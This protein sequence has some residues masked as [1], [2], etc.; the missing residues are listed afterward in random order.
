VLV[1]KQDM[2]TMLR[3]EQPTAS[4]RWSSMRWQ[5]RLQHRIKDM[6]VN[7]GNLHHQ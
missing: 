1:N 3:R 4:Q 7:I 5:G 2:A 6:G